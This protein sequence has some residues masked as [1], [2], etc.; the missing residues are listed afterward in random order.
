MK[1]DLTLGS[2]PFGP[3]LISSSVP[4]MGCLRDPEIE[5]EGKISY[6][7]SNSAPTVNLMGSSGSKRLVSK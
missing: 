1:S 7:A 6:F 4:V 3:L 5:V 2:S